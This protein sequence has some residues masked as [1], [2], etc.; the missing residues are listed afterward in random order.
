MPDNKALSTIS[1][2]AKISKE[3]VSQQKTAGKE[4]LIKKQMLRL[5]RWLSG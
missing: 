3:T 5:E 4:K 1:L 2:Y